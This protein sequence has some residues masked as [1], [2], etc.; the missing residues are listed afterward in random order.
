MIQ[1]KNGMPKDNPAGLNHWRIIREAKRIAKPLGYNGD[2]LTPNHSLGWGHDEDAIRHI[3][4]TMNGKIRM[5]NGPFAR[6]VARNIVMNTK[7]GQ[8]DG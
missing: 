8:Q 7:R 6:E 5:L 1:Q 3:V 2:A 4:L